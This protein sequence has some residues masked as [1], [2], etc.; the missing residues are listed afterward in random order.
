MKKHKV[1]NKG[2]KVKCTE[3]MLIDYYSIYG[4]TTWQSNLKPHSKV[5]MDILNPATPPES[6][7]HVHR[8]SLGIISNITCS[9]TSKKLETT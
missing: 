1:R 3:E 4:T 6:Q 5:M 7:R 2:R 9:K 8:C